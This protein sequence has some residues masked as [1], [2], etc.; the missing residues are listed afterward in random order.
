MNASTCTTDLLDRQHHGAWTPSMMAGRASHRLVM[1]RR[2]RNRLGVI[3]LAVC[4]L[5]GVRSVAAQPAAGAGRLE[6]LVIRQDGSGVGGVLVLIEELGRSELTDVTG[7]YA[8]GGLPPGIYTVLSTLGP[9]SLR[10]SGVVINARA[11]TTLRAVVDWPLNV[12]ESVV[13]NGTTRLPERLVDAPAAVTVVES[14]AIATQA[15][16]GQL[17]RVLAGT[18]GVELVQSGLYNFNLNSRGFNNFYNRYILTRIDGRDPSLPTFLGSVDW[19]ALSLPLDDID[20]IE[21]VRGPGAALYGAGAFNGI[22]N[23]RTR[24]P[25]DS[26][27]GKV[28][29]TVGELGTQ[30]IEVRQASAI[31]H[32]WYLKAMG[33]YHHSGDFTR[34]R[35]T[36]GE[37]APSTLP[38]DLVAPTL[39]K[40]RLSFGSVRIDKYAAADHLFSF[41]VGT[42]H[43]IG[44]VTL[45][46]AGRTQATD[47]D[48]PW[49]RV[50]LATP[51]WNVLAY[52]TGNRMDATSNLS[53]DSLIY[54]HA[55]QVAVEAQ[56]NRQFAR[57]RGRV[58]AGVE[59]GRQRADT[60]DP[61][62]VQ[63]GFDRQRS[64][65]YGSVFG[66]VEYRIT[67]RLNSVMSARWDLS[68]LHDS[69]VSPRLA[70]VYS[71]APSQTLRVTYGRAFQAA[72]LTEY[73]LSLPV[74]PPIDLSRVEASLTPLIGNTSLGLGNIPILALG[75]D[76]LRVEQ[77][78]SVEVGYQGVIGGRLLVNASVYRNQLKDFITFLLP[79]VGTSLGRLN[80]SFGPYTT[81]SSLSPAAAAI[82]TATLE[83]VLPPGLFASLSN[84]ATGRPVIALLSFGNFGSATSAGLELGATYL[85]PAGWS[86]QGSYTGF[87]SKVSGIPENPLSPNT[88]GHQ[89]GAGAA[90]GRGRFSGALRY[91]WVD[92]FRWLAGI[93]MSGRFRVMASSISTAAINSRSTSRPA[94]TLRTCLTMSITKR[95]AAISSAAAHSDI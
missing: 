28:R 59:F 40:V 10:Q 57:A 77:I 78:D 81:P 58:I 19:A 45:S 65:T 42:A 72:N 38:R 29:Y 17:P 86:I 85:L 41:E 70:A 51:R 48:Q 55:S 95:S 30:R 7:K 82:V 22:M 2:I 14:A 80:S 34:S 43:E 33:G 93:Y 25:R 50:N 3:C 62:G 52:Y 46:P 76:H 4:S 9:Q 44:P 13:V 36:S 68:S 20:Q 39:D 53:A 47:V 6:G 84:D 24:S 63:T 90:Y 92:S 89:F 67:E 37:Y 79:Q 87:H 54:L 1:S 74:A 73:F 15:L 61:N 32:D 5:A 35:V 69:R 88:S 49:F 75:N 12:F 23:V 64:T 56:T 31:G 8:F 66:Q 91:R 94:P 11:A 83:T 60:A 16:H 71:L 26:F 27:G 21:L 18:P